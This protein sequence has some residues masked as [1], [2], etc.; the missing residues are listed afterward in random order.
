[1]LPAVSPTFSTAGIFTNDFEL[2]KGKGISGTVQLPDG[3]PVPNATIALVDASDS[4]YM[5]RP[6]ELRR[7]SSS[8]DFQR[9]DL[10]GHF[11][12]APKFEAHTLIAAHD[13]GYAEVRASNVLANGIVVL[14]PWARVTGVVRVGPKLQPGRSVALQSFYYSYGQAG[15]QSPA[16]SL[17]LKAEPD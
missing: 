14:Q 6:G 9:S 12:F 2:K 4:A 11:E 8:G 3:T 15:R 16:L 5:D 13:K 7:T 1:Y 10:R 17:Y